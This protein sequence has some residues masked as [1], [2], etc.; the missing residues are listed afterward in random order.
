MSNRAPVAVSFLPLPY[1]LELPLFVLVLISIF[2]GAGVATLFSGFSLLRH[3]I[4]RLGNRRKIAAL[5]NEVGG[6][7]MERETILPV[8]HDA[9]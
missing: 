5:E 3:K 2:F 1:Q 9:N 7:R 4:E 6:L 8:R